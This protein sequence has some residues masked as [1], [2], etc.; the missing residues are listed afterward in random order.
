MLVL[1]ICI[2]RVTYFVKKKSFEPETKVKTSCQTKR[3]EGIR[4]RGTSQ[5]MMKTQE[6]PKQPGR[7]L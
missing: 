6:S 1:F 5:L 7:K 3:K 4:S 2:E